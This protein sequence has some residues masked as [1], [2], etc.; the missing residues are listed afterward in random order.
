M[1]LVSELLQSTKTADTSATQNNNN[2]GQHADKHEL[3]LS[4]LDLIDRLDAKQSAL[5][6]HDEVDSERVQK[7]LKIMS[8]ALERA[9]EDL[10]KAS[11]N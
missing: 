3:T 6:K 2:D 10:E 1:K 9:Y 7:R 4:I 8:G 5:R 11:G